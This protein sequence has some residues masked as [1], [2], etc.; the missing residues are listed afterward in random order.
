MADKPH[1]LLGSCLC[2]NVGYA[3]ADAFEYAMNCHCSQCRRSTGAAF[4]P[5]A[6]I[7]AADLAGVRGE[8]AILRFGDG[9][10][11]D[12]HCRVCGSLLYGNRL[13]SRK[14]PVMGQ[15]VRWFRKHPASLSYVSLAR[16]LRRRRR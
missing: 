12:V 6:G 1:V 13:G 7:A 15:L 14:R 2:G 3:V 9:H 4:K 8:Q 5:P 16:R 11:H 10:G